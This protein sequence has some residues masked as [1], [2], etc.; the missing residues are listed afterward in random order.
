MKDEA[1]TTVFETEQIERLLPT[2]QIGGHNPVYHY[3]GNPISPAEY[4]T[5]LYFEKILAVDL[6]HPFLTNPDKETHSR[7]MRELNTLL[8]MQNNDTLLMVQGIVKELLQQ[9]EY[10]LQVHQ[11]GMFTNSGNRLVAGTENHKNSSGK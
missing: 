10:L 3:N 1:R 9:P 4:G 6:S 5:I 11:W 2:K 8:A 7:L